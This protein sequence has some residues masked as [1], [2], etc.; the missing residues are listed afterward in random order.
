[1]GKL[2]IERPLSGGASPCGDQ[3]H[4]R[5]HACR[6]QTSL[7]EEY[8]KIIEA[9]VDEVLSSTGRPAWELF[10]V[11]Q[12]ALGTDPRARPLVSVTPLGLQPCAV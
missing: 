10:G 6:S 11:L 5:R 7:H 12:S 2:S 1:M 4:K 9:S 8:A 3:R